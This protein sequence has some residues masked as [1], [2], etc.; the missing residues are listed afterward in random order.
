MKRFFFIPTLILVVLVYTISIGWA[1][2]SE[3]EFLDFDLS[4]LMQVKVI[5]VTKKPQELADSAAA[6][7]VISSDDIR[8]SGVTSIPDALR[9]APGL[10]VARIS[11]NKWAITSRG[12]NGFFANKLLV[13]MDGR[14]IYTPA[15]SGV[16]WDCQ[17]YLLEDIDRIEVIR[18]P[19][20]AM[21][22][23]NAVNGVINIITKKATDTPGGLVS[24]G[25][26]S[27]DEAMVGL[28]YGAQLSEI[29]ASRFYAKVHERDES[30]LHGSSQDAGDNGTTLNTGFRI[31]GD[32]GQDIW[33]V[34]GDFY[35]GDQNQHLINLARL[36]PPWVY[37]ADDNYEILGWNILTRWQHHFTAENVTTLQVYY[38]VAEREEFYL[39]QDHKTFD[40][41]FQHQ[42]KLAGHELL[43]GLAF[44]SICSDFDNSFQVS[45]TPTTL[46][47]DLYSGFIQ[48]EISL[49]DTLHLT[50][51]S[52]I[53]H[54]DYTGVEV[55]PSVRL[56][57]QLAANQRLWAAVS[58]GV[59]TPSE[60]ES[61]GTMVTYVIPPF[62]TV[63]LNGDEHLDA[64]ELIA[65]ELGYRFNPVP[66][67]TFDVALYYNDYDNL[68]SY[69][70]VFP[71]SLFETQM[72]GY[73][74]GLELAANWQ[75]ENG[76]SV[77]LA[78]TY[79]KGNF[80][81]GDSSDLNSVPVAEG[82][83]P[84]QQVSLRTAFDLNDNWQC[85]F[86]LRYV[87]ELGTASI[88]AWNNDWDVNGYVD[89]DV[90]LSWQV[91]QNLRLQ[92]VGQNLLNSSHLEFIQESF[93]A[94]TEI[95]RSIYVKINW[96]F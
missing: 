73:N 72:D 80:N 82:S 17:D 16:Y 60:V 27:H 22:G 25:A 1:D 12:F 35:K 87:D 5:S 26:G 6:V 51:G 76:F 78:Y 15:F 41:D 57:W 56:L 28:R 39:N 42:F 23:A 8:R 65:Y 10:H 53:E 81:Q 62:T 48:D 74:Y 24:V 38:D 37:A 9:M 70:R 50:I 52:K 47:H 61:Y 4:E 43:W 77:Q 66:S 44:R 13:L 54:N 3:N 67:L 29:V 88:Q 92:L 64:E 89:L 11:S 96:E 45:F 46:Y 59:R 30:E 34:Q 84:Q 33:T 49:S 63:V 36:S 79:F 90:R 7:F 18:G 91:Q 93:T 55:Q 19:G 40:L 86:W 31:D 69:T 68:R 2:V 14:S 21:W 85:D 71:D 58:R 75:P 94:C 20:A 32:R 83:S 95:K